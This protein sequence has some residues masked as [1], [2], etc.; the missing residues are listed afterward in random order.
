MDRTAKLSKYNAIKKLISPYSE[1]GIEL[2]IMNYALASYHY[3]RIDDLNKEANAIEK[4][5]EKIDLPTD[6][7]TIIE[8]FEVLLEDDTRGEN[9]IVF[10]PKYIADYIV[11]NVLEEVNDVNP[12]FSV[13]DPACGCGIFLVSALE[14]LHK[15]LGHSINELLHF[16]HGADIEPANVRRC[17]LV[18]ALL[19][20]KYG[21]EPNF[22]ANIVCMD[23]L[24]RDWFKA[25]NIK[26]ADYIVGNP[27][28]VNP[29]DMNKETAEF[30]KGAFSTT[31]SG[32]FN[33]FYAFIECSLK[34]V[35]NY[36]KVGFIL[37]N[38]LFTIKSA[39][40]LRTFLQKNGYVRSILDFG[41]NMVFKPTRTYNCIMMFDKEEKNTLSYSVVEKSDDI[42]EALCNSKFSTMS[43]NALDKNG[44]TLV[45]QRTRNNLNQIESQGVQIKD[46]IRTGIATLK[47]NVYFVYRDE[48][49]YFKTIDGIKHYIE[50]QL[51]KPIYK[52]PELKRHDTTDEI[53][54]Y[55]IFPYM[56]T[57]A[58]YQL[59]DETA[60]R[61]N[62]PLT[63]ECLLLQ[64][65]ELDARDKGKGV[66]QGWYAYGRTQ[67]LNKYGKKLL[68]PTF[69]N[70]PKFMRVDVEDS[71]FCNGYAVFENEHFD[72]SL[73]EKILN[74]AI[75][76][77]Y[78]RNT[79]Y[80]IE[81]GYFCYQKKYIERFSIPHLTQSE[82]DFILAASQ[83]EVNTFLAKKYGLSQ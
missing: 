67:G 8:L 20:I 78:I 51:V 3:A 28:Y 76:D 34:Y 15:K 72:L 56:K 77:Y 35:S 12:A 83:R 64:K 38:N 57:Q 18:I 36:G 60:F 74:S 13:I 80:S 1:S 46:F 23:S 82:Q 52:V 71:L 32:V 9:G 21:E 48:G 73:L 63:Y 39:F 79:S 55:I 16:V 75:M 2:G 44:W 58:G 29:H 4:I 25:F 19:C 43:V 47:D 11:A 70:K 59:I 31:K 33:I 27:P 54:R 6:I 53:K 5:L 30:L 22:E 14:Y 49:G 37:P 62:F 69:A 81:G 40:D 42:K 7:E 50:P 61:A 45:D 66:P 24:K 68:F 10:T 26:T 65:D 41:S 17:K